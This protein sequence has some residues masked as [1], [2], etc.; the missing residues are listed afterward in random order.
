MNLGEAPGDLTQP[1]TKSTLVFAAP[2]IE[3]KSLFLGSS[4]HCYIHHINEQASDAVGRFG[5]KDLRPWH[6]VCLIKPTSENQTNQNMI[7]YSV[8]VLMAL[9]LWSVETASF[10][11]KIFLASQVVHLVTRGMGGKELFHPSAAWEEASGRACP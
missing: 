7:F 9:E 3:K 11:I 1:H 6:H 5:G 2:C 8:S 10:A 4:L